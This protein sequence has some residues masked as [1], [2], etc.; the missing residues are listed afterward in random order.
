M[1]HRS[2]LLGRCDRIAAGDVVAT[3]RG[4]IIFLVSSLIV[5]IE[6]HKIHMG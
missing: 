3:F 5:P 4:I 6:W 1:Q 2:I